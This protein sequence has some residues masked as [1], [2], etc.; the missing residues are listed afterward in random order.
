MDRW[1]SFQI[2]DSDHFIVKFCCNHDDNSKSAATCWLSD[3]TSLW[4]ESINTKSELLDRFFAENEIIDR[5]SEGIEKQV[6]DTIGTLPPDSNKNI[7]L[8]IDNNEDDR[9]IMLK[10]KYILSEIPVRFQWKL[11]KSDSKQFFDVITKSI[12]QQLFELQNRNEELVQII[13]SKNLEI[14]Q[15][16][17]DGAKPLMRKQFITPPFDE[18]DYP[19]PFQMVDCQNADITHKFGLKRKT[20]SPQKN[21]EENA[22]QGNENKMIQTAIRIT[23][24]KPRQNNKRHRGFNIHSAAIPSKFEYQN[25]KDPN[26]QPDEDTESEKITQSQPTAQMASK[27]AKISEK[28]G[29]RRDFNI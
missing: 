9:N 6:L 20:T 12:F 18:N 8:R 25:E 11:T 29:L 14:E 21:D 19:Q 15:Y 23:S 2:N 22:T 26:S 7:E 1:L 3:F 13:K 24:A 17:L 5:S 28:K 4:T 27:N 16:K 10:F